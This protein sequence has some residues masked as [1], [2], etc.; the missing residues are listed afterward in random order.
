MTKSAVVHEDSVFGSIDDINSRLRRTLVE[1]DGKVVYITETEMHEDGIPRLYVAP[2]PIQGGKA[3]RKI[4]NSP[5]FNRFRPMQ[6][7]WVNHFFEDMHFASYVS[8]R[9]VRRAKQGLAQDNFS[10]YDVMSITRVSFEK[11]I[12]SDGVALNEALNNIY[13][14]L[15]KL[16]GNMRDSSSVGISTEF[17]LYCDE[18]GMY[19]LYDRFTRVGLFFRGQFYLHNDY[20]FAKEK[21]RETFPN[22]PYFQERNLQIGW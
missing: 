6:L 20:E 19:W 5:L 3:T 12:R 1:Y 11:F 21:L 22:V 4:I 18:K 16:L 17:C 9:G 13:P 8:Q 10:S 14:T 15:D 7:G 2:L